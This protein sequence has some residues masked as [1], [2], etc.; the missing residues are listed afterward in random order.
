M[1]TKNKF[2][3]NIKALS[4]LNDELRQRLTESLAYIYFQCAAHGNSNPAKQWAESGLPAWIKSL[5]KK[6]E[7]KKV[8]GLDLE[9][10]EAEAMEAATEI[11]ERAFRA[12]EE[13][14]AEAKAKREAAKAEAETPKAEAEQ[15]LTK[16]QKAKA[17][18]EKQARENKARAEDAEAKAAALQETLAG[19]TL[20]VAG[21]SMTLT[22]EE[23]NFLLD[24]LKELRRGE[25]KAA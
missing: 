19:N 10:A 9:Q 14:R 12:Q 1:I 18:A 2:N 25:V 3:G 4:K 16:A 11:V 24:T 8:K 22:E 7:T 15:A 20:V 13:K 23:A 6:A 17:K 21:T 5:G